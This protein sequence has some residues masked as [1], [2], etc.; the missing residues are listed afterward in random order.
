MSL[1]HLLP[2]NFE[3]PR[4]GIYEM[5]TAALLYYPLPNNFPPVL[6]FTVWCWTSQ[7][8]QAEFYRSQISY[9][10]RGSGMPER[11]LGS[12]Y[13]QLNDIW[14]APTWSGIE[15]DGRWKLLHYIAKDIYKPVV[16]APYWDQ[17]RGNLTAYVTSDLWST[18]S[19]TATLQ[20]YS[21]DGSKL[22]N[23]TE[24][25]FK[26]GALNT[27]KVLDTNTLALSY[28]LTSS[29]LKMNITAIGTP[30]NSATS[31]TYTHE[32]YFHLWHL[33][34]VQ[35]P[36]PGV[37]LDYNPATQK[38]TVKATKGVGVFVWLDFPEGCARKFDENAFWLIPGDGGKQVGYRLKEDKSQTNRSWTE[39]VT[40]RSLWDNTCMQ[41]CTK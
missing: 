30:P 1:A 19:G 31:Q 23:K 33:N 22:G 38:F 14:Q 28:N 36:D 34:Q 40:I 5:T 3:S 32:S 17:D 12:L 11:Q 29:F 10:R 37:S 6:N 27:T 21:Y 13:W 26:V 25:S 8:F 20:W 18:A 24:I 4:Y 41:N 15:Y 39:S 16:I 2:T 9:Y 35:L 7:L